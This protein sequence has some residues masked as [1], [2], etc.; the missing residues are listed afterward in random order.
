MMLH[1]HFEDAD[2]KSDEIK[3]EEQDAR[4]VAKPEDANIIAEGE[5][6]LSEPDKPKRT[7]KRTK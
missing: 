1:R 6:I 5:D 3:Q 7:R 4:T 2:K